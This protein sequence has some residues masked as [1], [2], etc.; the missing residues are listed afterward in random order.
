TMF[1][2]YSQGYIVT[3]GG[4]GTLDELFEAITLAQTRKVTS[5][6]VVLLGTSYWS[7]LIDW[8]RDT[9]LADGKI[10]PDDLE[11]FHLTDDIDEAVA[12]FAHP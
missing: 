5:F 2:K 3:P 9:V 12:R 1:V 11:R 7:G 10:V 6:P 8:L 4:F